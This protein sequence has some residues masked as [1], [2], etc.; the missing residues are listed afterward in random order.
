VAK[1][2]PEIPDPAARPGLFQPLFET[3]EIDPTLR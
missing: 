2:D 1:I 3:V